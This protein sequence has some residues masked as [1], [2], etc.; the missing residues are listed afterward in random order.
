MLSDGMARFHSCPTPP[1]IHGADPMG[2]AAMNCEAG[3]A[4]LNAGWT[5]GRAARQLPH[6]RHREVVGL[7]TNS[8]LVGFGRRGRFAWA[9]R[10]KVAVARWAKGL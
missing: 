7:R 4:R 1:L 9:R 6:V 10:F 5:A 3:I 8:G 2:I